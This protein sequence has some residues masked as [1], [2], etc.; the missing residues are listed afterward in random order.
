MPAPL[1]PMKWFRNR[2]YLHIEQALS[3]ED[4]GR[5]IAEGQKLQLTEGAIHGG[6]ID[7]QVR[8]SKIAMFSP[9][10]HL[11]LYEK[12]SLLVGE[13]NAKHFGFDLTGIET[14]QYSEYDGAEEGHYHFHRDTFPALTIRKL[15]LSVLLSEPTYEGGNLELYVHSPIAPIVATRVRGNG[16][17]FPSWT[18]HG[19]KP[20]T[21]GLRQALVAWAVGP[22]FR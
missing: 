12:I 5:V 13:V 15:S 6:K 11:W 20:V 17:I 2:D 21:K 9:Q 3:Q 19:V 18:V 10:Q 4:C 22:E 14:I 7:H 1:W 8:R 16:I